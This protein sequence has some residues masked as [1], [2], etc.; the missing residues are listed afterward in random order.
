MKDNWKLFIVK[1]KTFCIYIK[2][3][4]KI[5]SLIN[6]LLNSKFFIKY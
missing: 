6:V 4:E 2:G 5:L 1:F 3:F